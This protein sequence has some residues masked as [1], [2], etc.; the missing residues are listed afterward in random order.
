MTNE[1]QTQ[2]EQPKSDLTLLLD[3]LRPEPDPERV[4]ELER[5]RL[6]QAK[7]ALAGSLVN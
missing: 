7:C 4:A 2:T 5:T 3:Y 6:E 1:N